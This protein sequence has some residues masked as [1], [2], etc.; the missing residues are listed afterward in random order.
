V[1]NEGRKSDAVG[2]EETAEVGLAETAASDGA[3]PSV[4]TSSVKFLSPGARVGR[5]VITQTIGSGGMGVVYRAYDPELSRDVALKLL[6]VGADGSTGSGRE[7][8]LLREAQAMARL[9]HPNVVAVHDVGLAD[10]GVFIAMEFV[11]GQTLD[12][13][14]SAQKRSLREIIDVFAGAGHGLIAAHHAGLV[15]RDFK[16][17]NVIVS[18]TG[19][20]RVVD[21]GLAR[22]AEARG[23]KHG[24]TVPLRATSETVTLAGAIVGTPAYMA[25]EQHLG[26]TVDHRADQFSFCV[27]LWEAVYG[28]RPFLGARVEELVEHVV[29]GIRE[30]PPPEIKVP[31]RLV[32]LLDRGLERAPDARYPT[33]D[34]LV[35]DLTRA[36][37]TRH[38]MIVAAAAIAGVAAVGGGAL[39]W[40]AESHDRCAAA[41]EPVTRVWTPDARTTIRTAFI[42]TRRPYAADSFER[43]GRTLDAYATAWS[44]MSRDAC[45][46][47]QVRGVQSGA[48]LDRRTQCLDRRLGALRATVEVLRKAD[49]DVVDRAAAMAAG[50]PRIDRCADTAALEAAYPPPDDEAMRRQLERAASRLD[51]AHALLEAGR[52]REGLA[53]AREVVGTGHPAYPP[54]DARGRYLVGRLLALSGDPTAAEP[55]LREAATA[56]AAARDDELLARIWIEL[57]GI[58]AAKGRYQEAHAVGLTADAAVVRAGGGALLRADLDFALAQALFE[59]GKITEAKDAATRALSAREQA[60]GQSHL[61]VARAAAELAKSLQRLGKL[62][63]AGEQ[64]RRALPVLEAALGRDHPEVGDHLAIL[65]T[66]LWTQGKLDEALSTRNRVLAIREA[67]FGAKNAMVARALNGVGDVLYDMGKYEDAKGYYQRAYDTW[68]ATVGPDDPSLRYALHNLG[69]VARAQ[70]KFDEARQWHERDLALRERVM[71]KQHPSVAFSLRALGI[72]LMQQGEYDRARELLLRALA[73]QEA[74]VGHDHKDTAAVMNA[75]G[76]VELGAAHL[77]AAWTWHEKAL[78]ARVK[79]L[80]AEH[81]EVGISENNLGEILEQRGRFREAIEHFERSRQIVEKAV[82]A[83]HPTL[84]YPLRGLGRC[85]LELGQ[86]REAVTLLERALELRKKDVPDARELG[87]TRFTLARAL[88]ATDRAR[89]VELAREAQAELAA[90]GP[91]EKALQ[92]E[93]ATWLRAHG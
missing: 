90:A 61:F 92:R 70:G 86:T 39:M 34:A 58:H 32:R 35:A 56:A 19:R 43:V 73:L 79:A 53:I 44:G 21:F 80:G 6:K 83:E 24:R 20:V 76:N 45:E 78:A 60:L 16:P 49:G 38:R 15:H 77:D 28:R 57:L 91:G 62:D 68:I 31:P 26:E 23:E 17:S 71:G 33:M 55:V 88:V 87:R 5:Y 40:R 64:L 51:D 10:E 59:E 3:T 66:L 75:L 12:A 81:F 74:T 42:A 36:T 69:E 37:P 47:T 46:A 63:E 29:G 84:A 8:R 41:A 7:G 18:P 11:E 54:V 22:A 52:Y 2:L 67:A 1:S 50:L 9:Q 13:W 72:V 30:D 82:G 25:P 89:A 14:L 93:V 65:G 85:R 27:A 4:A 48:M